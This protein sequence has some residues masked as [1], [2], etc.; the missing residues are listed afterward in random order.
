MRPL[1]LFYGRSAVQTGC[2][3]KR[4]AVVRQNG[5]E[6]MDRDMDLWNA[7][8]KHMGHNVKITSRV[9]KT[10]RRTSYCNVRTAISIF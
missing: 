2:N 10:T 8:Q 7:L 1:F 9:R 5:K 3:T 6:I 4:K